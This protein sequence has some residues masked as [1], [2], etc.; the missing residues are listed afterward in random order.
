MLSKADSFFIEQAEPLAGFLQYLRSYILQY[1]IHIKEV[2]QYSMPFYT[3]KGKR[4]CYIWIHRQY[5][6]PYLGFVEGEFMDHPELLKEK[7]KRMSILLLDADEDVPLQLINTLLK[8]A[9][10]FY[11]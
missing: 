5:K 9:I 7:R 3:Y 6:K 2:W 11:K 10:S 4:L 8:K 1:D